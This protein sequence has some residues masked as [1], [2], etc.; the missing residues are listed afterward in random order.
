M[1][2][3]IFLKHL[4]DILKPFLEHKRENISQSLERLTRKVLGLSMASHRELY[5][6]LVSHA[7]VSQMKLFFKK[8]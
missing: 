7:I 3:I 1:E 6:F 5:C 8:N 4:Q 2:M